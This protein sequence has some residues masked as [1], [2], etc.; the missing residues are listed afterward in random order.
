MKITIRALNLVTSW[1]HTFTLE[2]GDD[3]RV[4][5]VKRQCIDHL[6]SLNPSPFEAGF[7]AGLSSSLSFHGKAIEDGGH[8]TGDIG[9]GATLTFIFYNQ[10]GPP[11]LQ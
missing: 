8:L 2:L 7:E 3:T 9:T 1:M 11:A 6:K 4:N 10:G 5:S